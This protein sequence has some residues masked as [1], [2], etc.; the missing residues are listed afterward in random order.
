L[1]VAA[2]V[3]E[4]VG[5]VGVPAAQDGAGVDVGQPDQGSGPLA[6]ERVAGPQEQ[7]EQVPAGL[8]LGVGTTTVTAAHLLRREVGDHR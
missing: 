6:A 4:A 1:V 2:A 3:G 8:L 5:A 7:P